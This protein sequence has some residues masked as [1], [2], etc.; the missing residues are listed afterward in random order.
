MKE[1]S[2]VRTSL[3]MA[4]ALVISLS[5]LTYASAESELLSSGTAQTENTA[6]VCTSHRFG[7][8][9]VTKAATTTSEG[10]RTYTCIE[11]GAVTTTATP[12]LIDITA[13]QIT[14]VSAKYTYN[15]KIYK[16]L[17]TVTVDGKELTLGRDYI[18]SYGTNKNPGTG[19]VTV[20]GNGRYGGTLKKTFIIVPAK[21]V[22]SKLTSTK[23]STATIKFKKKTGATGY[24]IAY[25]TNK[26]FKAG[27]V[28]YVT[29]K[30][31]KLSTTIK[32]LKAGKT[33]YF[34]VQAYKTISGKKYYGKF[35]AVK[36]I[37]I[38]QS[39]SQLKAAK[40]KIVCDYAKA[41][42]GGA[43]VWCGL[44]FR[45]TDCSGL[46]MQ[47]FEQ[48]GI[49]L[50]HNAAAQAS[51]GTAVSYSDMQPGDLIICCGGGHAALYVGD[52]Y[53]VHAT[54][55]GRGIVMDPVSQLQYY[56]I[57]TIRRLI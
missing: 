22:I 5:T 18:L 8:G 21:G 6:V 33:Y 3:T 55:P 17:P 15:G 40:Q 4:T 25:S 20:T 12:K 31:N 14:G 47:C 53:F 35:S 1:R 34:K 37:K 28:K 2:I 27:T 23:A 13:A 51:Y 30:A 57:D 42:V 41:N 29:V 44:S 49:Y 43:Y 38:K 19:Y 39:A 48:I 54:N 36:K 7:T 16:P 11:C 10:E 26:S 50:P 52:G 45:A 24:R 46:T 56:G 32:K 9:I